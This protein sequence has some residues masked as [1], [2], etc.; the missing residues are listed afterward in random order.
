MQD[1][2][3]PVKQLSLAENVVS[4]VKLEYEDGMPPDRKCSERKNE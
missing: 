3:L 1:K 2:R 4:D